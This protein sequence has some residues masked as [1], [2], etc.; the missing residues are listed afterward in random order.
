MDK[1]HITEK[2]LKLTLEIIYLLTGED[3][4]VVSRAGKHVGTIRRTPRQ[5]GGL[6]KVI[7]PITHPPPLSE[8][9]EKNNN[10][11]ILDL[12]NKIIQL[13]TGEV[14]IRCEDVIVCFSM[15][16][17]KYVEGHKDLYKHIMENHPFLGSSAFSSSENLSMKLNLQM[18]TPDTAYKNHSSTSCKGA[19][20]NNV[21]E[22]F[23][24]VTL[25]V[26]RDQFTNK[27]TCTKYTQTEP[28]DCGE[29]VLC[30][31]KEA[32][33]VFVPTENTMM[34]CS[35][36]ASKSY[37]KQSPKDSDFCLLTE[38]IQN[39]PYQQ[40]SALEPGE[41]IYTPTCLKSTH[42]TDRPT[43]W[44]TNVNFVE[45]PITPHHINSKYTSSCII[46]V[47]STCEDGDV[48]SKDVFTPA[49]HKTY[50]SEKIE[51]TPMSW[52]K[53]VIYTNIYT[54]A[55]LTQADLNNIK[56]ELDSW[57]DGSLELQNIY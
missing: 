34:G 22:D 52:G 47:A 16:E 41:D 56:K 48:I 46:E 40:G 57:E 29:E 1:D 44:V 15:E 18:L 19:V 8:V 36:D 49:D 32:D 30:E 26:E 25:Q 11:K 35:S 13:L 31:D 7:S 17:W 9:H 50:T 27:S 33:V 55:E 43:E 12:T 38:Q 4:S 21:F 23:Q 51:E 54:P 42:L 14:P 39:A 6:C 28:A 2:I 10:L 37:N 5:T 20:K 3:Y 53:D 45:C 24:E